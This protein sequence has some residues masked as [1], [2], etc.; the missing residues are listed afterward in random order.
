VTRASWWLALQLARLRRRRLRGRV[1]GAEDVIPRYAAGKSFADVGCMWNIH[2]RLAFL[3]ADSGANEVVGVDYME[4]TPEFDREQSRRGSPVRFVRG[5]IHDPAV[6]AEVGNVDVAFCS[7]VLYHSP[8]PLHT[9]AALRGI[10]R[11]TLL[12][13]TATVPE[14]PGTRNGCVFLPHLDD[15]SRRM[16]DRLWPGHMTGVS[17]PF[18]A[19][20]GYDNWFW[21]L[22]PSAVR[23]MIEASGF[24]VERQWGQ[25]FTTSFVGRAV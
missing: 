2:G 15:R 19:D 3:A 13:W 23:S 6:A 5:D 16:Y 17:D 24:R 9:L 11:E 4:P 12:L 1:E 18:S 7:G 20:A 22:S 14:L 21:A 25:P 8:N 10:C